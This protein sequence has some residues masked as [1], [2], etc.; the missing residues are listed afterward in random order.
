MAEKTSHTL[1]PGDLI[2]LE[3]RSKR[4][5]KVVIETASGTK[6]TVELSIGGKL[7]LKVGAESVNINLDDSEHSFNGLHLVKK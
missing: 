6:M 1:K 5:K 3:N 4:S 7:E 2:H